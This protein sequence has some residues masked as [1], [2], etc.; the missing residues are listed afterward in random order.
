MLFHSHPEG[1]DWP[2]QKDLLWIQ[3]HPRAWCI[4]PRGSDP[5]WLGDGLP[6]QIP[7]N[8]R[9]FRYGVTDCFQLLRQALV[10]LGIMLR[11]RA[12][13][14]GWWEEGLS[15]YDDYFAEEGFTELGDGVPP[16]GGDVF[17]FSLRARVS[18]HAGLYVG[19]G[20]MLHHPAS[21]KPYDPTYLSRTEPLG[22][23]LRPAFRPRHLRHESQIQ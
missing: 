18:N 1:F 20:K 10:P 12:Y 22:R 6:W 7:L 11:P 16:R 19:N 14:W 13:A 4:L 15:L 17:L 8:G 23:Y 2:S 9:P 5:F 21:S 3:D